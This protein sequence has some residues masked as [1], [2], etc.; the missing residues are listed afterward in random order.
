M[1]VLSFQNGNRG[2]LVM[3]NKGKIVGLLTQ[4][5]VYVQTIPGIFLFLAIGLKLFETRHRVYY[6]R[7]HFEKNVFRNRRVKGDIYKRTVCL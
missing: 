5:P 2:D 6:C 4:N 3:L 7:A 1:I